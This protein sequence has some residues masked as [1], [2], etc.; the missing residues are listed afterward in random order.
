MDREI[1]R[2]SE[3]LDSMV[4]SI[5]VPGTPFKRDGYVID[6]QYRFLEGDMKP[7]FN[8]PVSAKV[9]REVKDLK[10]YPDYLKEMVDKGA[11]LLITRDDNCLVV[12]SKDSLKYSN[13]IQK[14]KIH[15]RMLLG[16]I[17][18][19][20]TQFRPFRNNI[21]QTGY[22]VEGNPEEWK[23]TYWESASLG[24]VH[25]GTN[26]QE[27]LVGII[28]GVYDWATKPHRPSVITEG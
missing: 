3:F 1:S 12:H 13:E 4:V 18:H 15:E 7:F 23:G 25:A 14:P 28:N 19:I 17:I 5:K 6:A 27:V 21:P 8:N 26:R 24:G 10:G 9:R 20:K 2:G 22:T 11:R 16:R